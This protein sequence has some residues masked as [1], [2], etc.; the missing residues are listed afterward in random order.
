MLFSR[1]DSWEVGFVWGIVAAT[2][3]NI[4]GAIVLRIV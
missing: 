4:I 3:G 2:L 1:K